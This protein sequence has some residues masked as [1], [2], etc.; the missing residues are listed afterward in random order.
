MARSRSHA[1]LGALV[2]C[3]IAMAPCRAAHAATPEADHAAAVESFRRG[4]LLVERGNLQDAIEAFREALQHEPSSVGARLDIADCYEKVGAPAP[5]W[6]EYTLAESYAQ[7]ANDTRRAL[8][9]SSAAHLEPRLF[10]VTLSGQT[11]AAMRVRADG[12]A[13]AD[14]IVARGTFALAPGSHRIEITAPG[15]KALAIDVAGGAGEARLLPIALVDDTPTPREPSRMPEESTRSSSQKTWGIVVGGL[16][17]A[18]IVAGSITGLVAASKKTTLQTEA[19][20]PTIGAARFYDDRS[21]AKTFATVSTASFVAGGVGLA[22]GSVLFF[23]APSSRDRAA[24][25]RV[26]PTLGGVVIDT[27]F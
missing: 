20:D 18:G 7:K 21:V 1:R 15:K 14:E 11:A 22:A 27:T 25:V 24:R 10:V 2:A 19:T 4:T 5:A 8:A 17:L 3:A 9:R 26:R 12:E 13:I 6:R 16:G 23:T